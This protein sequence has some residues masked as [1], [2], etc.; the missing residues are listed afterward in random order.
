MRAIEEEP[1]M[2][3]PSGSTVSLC[4]ASK[5][6]YLSAQ[7]LKL[8]NSKYHLGDNE[9]FII[10]VNINNTVSFKTIYG[11]YL[12][13]SKAGMFRQSHKRG[14]NKSEFSI[15]LHRDSTLQ[16]KTYCG[17]YVFASVLRVAHG[18]WQY[19]TESTHWRLVIINPHQD[20]LSVLCLSV[21]E[22]YIVTGSSAK[23]VMQK[24]LDD[25][26]RAEIER[27][28]TLT[29][30][31]SNVISA[32]DLGEVHELEIEGNAE[33]WNIEYEKKFSK[34]DPFIPIPDLYDTSDLTK[35]HFPIQSFVG[36][37]CF[38]STKKNGTIA[39]EPGLR[40][41]SELFTLEPHPYWPNRFSFKTFRNTYL[42]ISP[43]GELLQHETRGKSE[44]FILQK[45]STGASL[46][47]YNGHYVS[48]KNNGKYALEPDR[49]IS[50]QF[51]FHGSF[52]PVRDN[53]DAKFYVDGQEYYSE[54]Y[55]YLSQAHECI[56]IAGWFLSP[57]LYLI[58]PAS[59]PEHVLSTIL[60]DRA[61][62]G[63]QIRILLY[64]N[65]ESIVPNKHG[66]AKSYLEKL[67]HNIQVSLQP[68]ATM[69]PS[70]WS[71]HQKFVV[72]DY[73][74]A[75]VGGL[76]LCLYRYDTQ[77]HDV[78]ETVERTFIG[79]DYYNG[80]FTTEADLDVHKPFQ[81]GGVDR[82]IHPRMPWHDVHL[83]V[84]GPACAD[85]INNFVQRW[86]HSPAHLLNNRLDF[87]E[88]ASGN[89]NG[90][91]TCQVVRSISG[92][93]NGLHTT[94]TSIREAYC[95]TIAEADSFVYIE[96]QYFIDPTDSAKPAFICRAII[97]RIVRAVQENKQFQIIVVLPQYPDNGD[98]VKSSNSL[99]VMFRQ[100]QTIDYIRTQIIERTGSLGAQNYISFYSLRNYGVLG[101]KIVTEQ[102]YV[103]AKVM[104]SDKSSVIGSANINARSLRGNRDTELSVVVKN[105]RFSASLLK[106][107]LSEHTGIIA[108]EIPDDFISFF[109]SQWVTIA[110]R[111]TATYNMIFG[112]SIPDGEPTSIA[113]YSA[114]LKFSQVGIETLPELRRG[115]CGHLVKFP[116]N[117]L[118]NE[119]NG[120]LLAVQWRFMF[121]G[122]RKVSDL[123]T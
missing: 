63:V 119:Q 89:G 44:F 73:K 97:N 123:Y 12:R 98:P 20:A 96:N 39:S 100:R 82:S 107:L 32:P 29:A 121:N 26:L 43:E 94:E 54:L 3:I 111:N 45:F 57:N 95:K 117:F 13:A 37:I 88:I 5:S 23:S 65:V 80:R 55:N 56:Y 1:H 118:A 66:E 83:S 76:D 21:D 58:R 81:V 105:T 86:N 2:V 116:F 62:R 61:K 27:K 102:I 46:Q 87:K 101:D 75:F 47:A 120:K 17:T 64:N 60:H 22:A 84:D 38:M 51:H 40:G 7:R 110:E 91:C 9:K 106:K 71:H 10:E 99:L 35:S 18:D 52:S 25:M 74:I 48:L 14:G 78:V 8:V 28:L 68:L 15:L 72:V 33:F 112:K 122:W 113:E 42:S 104:I 24:H 67:H 69:I 90:D 77:N 59:N 49:L 114:A 30:K 50:T 11:N 79:K 70:S 109:K 92:R 4:L 85:I 93:A 53:I 115:I 19:H 41:D 31:S 6:W 103:H 36:E 34:E 108:A 16:I